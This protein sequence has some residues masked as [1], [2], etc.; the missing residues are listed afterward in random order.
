MSDYVVLQG[1]AGVENG[2][3]I[4]FKGGDIISDSNHDIPGLR[5]AGCSLMAFDEST[6]LDAVNAFRKSKASIKLDNINPL[7]RALGVGSETFLNPSATVYVDNKV[8]VDGERNGS[9]ARPFAN[10][11]DAVDFIAENVTTTS[12]DPAVIRIAT[13]TYDGRIV[14]RQNGIVLFGEDP[15]YTFLTSST[16]P[17][18]QITNATLESLETYNGSGLYS[19]LVY[20]A[21]DDVPQ[22]ISLNNLYIA[23]LAPGVVSAEFLGVKGDASPTTTNFGWDPVNFVGFNA[24]QVSFSNFGG[25]TVSFFMKNSGFFTMTR[26]SG[27]LNMNFENGG[28]IYLDHNSLAFMN[29]GYDSASSDGQPASGPDAYRFVQSRGADIVLSDEAKLSVYCGIFRGIDL[30]GT[31]EA[32]LRQ[33]TMDLDNRDIDLDDS[34]VLNAFDCYFARDVLVEQNASFYLRGCHV[35]RHINIAS[36]G[37]GTAQMDG[38]RYMGTL[39]DPGAKFVRNLGN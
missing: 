25:G 15:G 4:R 30:D 23:S 27:G 32:E 22:F 7:F 11:Q 29:L 19:D 2:Q 34:S 13:G 6:M 9:F 37:T 36:G 33:Y 31:C 3:I 14:I 1:F 12:L 16:G 20:A 5:N 21:G 10:I 24:N 39:T 8:T 18:L 38:G 26:G 35:Q 17:A 28:N